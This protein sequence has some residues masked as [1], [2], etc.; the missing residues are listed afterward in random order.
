MYKDTAK[1]LLTFTPI[2]AVITLALTLGPRLNAIV[3]IGL[4][5]WVRR[6]PVATAAI[7]LTLAATVAV[8]AL[9]RYVLLAE[10]TPWTELRKSP[11]WWSR[12]FSDH[13]VGMP[14]FPASTDFEAAEIRATTDEA[15]SAQ[16]SALAATTLRIQALSETLNA[17]ARF[18]RFSW[19]YGICMLL[20]VTGLSVAAFSVP[21]TP[22]AVTKPTKVAILLPDGAE[23]RFTETTGCAT[24][25]GTT[26]VAVGGLWDHPAIRLIG[27]GCPAGQ[28]TPPDD[29]GM[30]ITP[31]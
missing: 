9:C 7:V 11:T 27:P 26:A 17:K 19:G 31:A 4:D 30:V 2:T 28:W 23:R 3:G 14:L 13:A 10:A 12:A 6:F 8:V 5:G 20:I 15:T 1:W 24:L 21:A 16:Q 25:D 22:E 29:L 18:L